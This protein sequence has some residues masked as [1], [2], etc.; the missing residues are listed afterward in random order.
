MGHRP[1]ALGFPYDKS[2]SVDSWLMLAQIW[3]PVITPNVG[4]NIAKC[5]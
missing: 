1:V 4:D 3:V 2:S 5:R